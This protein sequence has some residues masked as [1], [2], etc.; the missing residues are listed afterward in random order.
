[1]S[2]VLR[3]NTPPNLNQRKRWLRLR[4]HR[5]RPGRAPCI[6]I[7]YT[8]QRPSIDPQQL[9]LPADGAEHPHSASGCLGPAV[10]LLEDTN[11]S[12]NVRLLESDKPPSSKPCCNLRSTPAMPNSTYTGATDSFASP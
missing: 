9:T 7:T 12:P 2:T 8:R 5:H 4:G 11:N 6:A 1:M 10:P 3:E